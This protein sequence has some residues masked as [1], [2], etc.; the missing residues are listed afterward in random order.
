MR[1]IVSTLLLVDEGEAVADS[2]AIASVVDTEDS[3]AEEVA[4]E[5]DEDSVGASMVDSAVVSVVHPV[6]ASVVHSVAASMVHS[7][8][9]STVQPVVASMVDSVTAKMVDSVVANGVDSVAANGVDIAGVAA[10]TGGAATGMRGKR[11]STGDVD[12]DGE[13]VV[14]VSPVC[15]LTKRLALS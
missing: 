13:V 4:T 8:V 12:E 7:V 5:A 2:A 14:V 9:A 3:A 10:S 1:K 6:V 11:E 15:H